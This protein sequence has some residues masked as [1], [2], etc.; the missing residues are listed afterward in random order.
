MVSGVFSLREEP[1]VDF[2]ILIRDVLAAAEAD[3]EVHI[4][5]ERRDRL[6]G[7]LT[8]VLTL[9]DTLGVPISVEQTLSPLVLTFPRPQEISC[10][11]RA[12]DGR[13]QKH[14]STSNCTDIGEMLDLQV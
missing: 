13:V 3:E 1:S 12:G 2:S 9:Q 11:E 7:F 5:G 4:S 6:A 14:L 10:S 8:E